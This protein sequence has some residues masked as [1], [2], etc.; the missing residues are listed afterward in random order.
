MKTSNK[1][2][3]SACIV[4]FVSLIVYDL[5]LKASFKSGTYK[6]PYLG[7]QK[8][9]VKKFDE[10]FLKTPILL[11]TKISYGDKYE[12]WVHDDLRDEIELSIVGGELSVNLIPKNGRKYYN[13][14][15]TAIIIRCPLLSQ[16]TTRLSEQS[17]LYYYDVMSSNI[18]INGFNQK[19]MTLYGDNSG[20]LSLYNNRI[21]H[22]KAVVG[23]GVTDPSSLSIFSTNVIDSANI[24]V[25]AKSGLILNNPEIK[26]PNF[27]LSDSAQVI[28]KASDLEKF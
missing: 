23:N 14:Y 27:K 5:G 20:I 12:F 4:L 24:T 18:N 21:Q 8:I 7:M 3:I 1:L 22:L 28:L 6:S 19:S 17:R 11:N 26:N 10:V 15:K 13:Y 2:L 25:N 9:P 16:L